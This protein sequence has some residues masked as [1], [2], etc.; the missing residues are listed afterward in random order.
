MISALNMRYR[1]YRQEYGLLWFYF[2][3]IYA[4]KEMIHV[5]IGNVYIDAMLDL[6]LKSSVLEYMCI[7]NPQDVHVH[8]DTVL[9][10]LSSTALA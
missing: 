2:L 7:A 10:T 1:V 8:T 4:G 3:M 9:K 6:V 5:A